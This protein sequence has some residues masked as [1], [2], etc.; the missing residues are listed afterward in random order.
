MPGHRWSSVCL[1]G[2]KWRPSSTRVNAVI[3]T[4]VFLIH[5]VY[6]VIKLAR[7]W[8]TFKIFGPDSLIP[9]RRTLFDVTAMFKWFF[10]MAPPV[11]DRWTYWEKFDLLGA[12]LGR[13]SWDSAD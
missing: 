12:V 10:G 13:P 6:I 9:A 1:A 2:R 5:L 11:F 7:N 4:A 8:K 3:F